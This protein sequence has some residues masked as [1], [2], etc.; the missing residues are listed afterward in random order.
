MQPTDAT[1]F[2]KLRAFIHLC[3]LIVWMYACMHGT[4]CWGCN[5]LHLRLHLRGVKGNIKILC[6]KCW[7]KWGLTGY[8]IYIQV[9]IYSRRCGSLAVAV[10]RSLVL[11]PISIMCHCWD[12]E[13]RGLSRGY[14]N[15]TTL[16]A[17]PLAISFKVVL[18][19]RTRNFF[20]VKRYLLLRVLMFV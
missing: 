19:L 17:I 6:C 3:I 1:P 20:V 13:D 14:A 10:S 4:L 9:L 18:G 2:H 15:A 5:Y 7:W 16:S 12:S 8:N 11:F